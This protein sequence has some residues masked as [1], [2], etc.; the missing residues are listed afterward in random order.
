[1]S[2]RFYSKNQII[3]EQIC[4]GNFS[5]LA[6]LS[7]ISVDSAKCIVEMQGSD[8]FLNGLTEISPS[9]ARHLFRWKGNWICLNG[10]RALSPRVAAYLFQWEGRWISLNGLTDFPPEIGNQLLQW[11]GGQLELMGL[12]YTDG[13]AGKIGIKYLAQWERSGGKL[14]VPKTIRKKIDEINA[15]Q[16]SPA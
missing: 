4:T 16:R 12:R 13:S 6:E 11:G 10:F 14:F 3:F 8:L 2:Q 9:A 1:L 5:R 7:E 15:S